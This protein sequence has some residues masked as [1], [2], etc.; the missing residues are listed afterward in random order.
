MLAVFSVDSFP[1]LTSAFVLKLTS[2][3]NT[4]TSSLT[5][6]ETPL[7]IQLAAYLIQET[8][9]TYRDFKKAPDAKKR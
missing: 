4:V 2:R 7:L 5:L 1:V 6:G 3:Q 8:P 9:K